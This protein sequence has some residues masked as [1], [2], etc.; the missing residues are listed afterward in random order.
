MVADYISRILIEPNK[1]MIRDRFPDEQLFSISST[2]LPWFAHIVN[3][4]VVGQVPSH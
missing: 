4:L 1:E 3:Y 2:G